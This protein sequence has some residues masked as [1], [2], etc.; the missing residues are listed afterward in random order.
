MPNDQGHSFVRL[1]SCWFKITSLVCLPFGFNFCQMFHLAL[2]PLEAPSSV[3]A[4]SSSVLTLKGPSNPK[5]DEPVQWYGVLGDGSMASRPLEPAP[6]S[7]IVYV[8]FVELLL[9]EVHLNFD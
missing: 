9:F 3:A 7:R 6:V 1:S 2:H 5:R 8:L 4:L